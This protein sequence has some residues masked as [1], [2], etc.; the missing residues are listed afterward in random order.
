MHSNEAYTLGENMVLFFSVWNVSLIFGFN[1]LTYFQITF[2]RSLALLILPKTVTDCYWSLLRRLQFTVKIIIYKL[3]P[4][5]VVT[6][7]MLK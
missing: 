5:Q 6:S 7:H 2:P 1:K 3:S 4:I